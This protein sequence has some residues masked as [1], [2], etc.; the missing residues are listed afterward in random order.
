MSGRLV[1]LGMG[2]TISTSPSAAGREP[3]RTASELIECLGDDVTRMHLTAR[4]VVRMHGSAVGPQQVWEL[5]RTIR[6]EFARGATGV[7]VTHGTDTL[8]ETAYGLALLL[9]RDAPVV[10]TGAMRGMDVPGS[11]G[12]AN[13]VAAVVAAAT[14]ELA[15]YGPVVVFQDEVHCARWVTKSHTSRVAPFSSPASGP[16]GYI[17]EGRVRLVTGP[18]KGIDQLPSSRM[19]TARVELIWAVSGGDGLL[20]DRIADIADGIVVAG[21]GGGHVSPAL[22]DSLLA[23]VDA[24]RPAVLASRC[25]NGPVLRDTYGGSGSERRLLA[26]GLVDA[27]Q[28]PPLKAR[29]RLLYG[30]SAGLSPARLFQDLT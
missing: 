22:A 18:P 20:V 24:G 19:P 16:I 21:T 5:A 12:P 14:P 8:E 17:T 25:L 27:G 9:A 26:G 10:L 6:E 4:D 30:I 29:L 7:V 28:L 13:L 1:V 11:D 3:S 23:Y 2:G 15:A